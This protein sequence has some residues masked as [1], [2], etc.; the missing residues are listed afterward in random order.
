MK[1]NKRYKT[2]LTGVVSSL[3]VALASVNANAMLTEHD[4]ASE[5]PQKTY[6][7]II[8][9]R[10]QKV[11]KGSTRSAER[12]ANLLSQD[13]G[14]TLKYVRRTASNSHVMQLDRL[15]S[16]A[17]ANDIAEQIAM[18]PD[19]LYAEPD[20]IRQQAAIP[21][22]PLY[23]QQWNYSGF[24][25][26]GGINLPDAWDISTGKDVVVAVIDTGYRPHEDLQDKVL[27]GY[28]FI[29]DSFMA[30]D[31]N[32]RDNDAKDPGDWLEPGECGDGVPFFGQNSSWHGTHVAGTIAA[33][34]D[35][36]IGV[37][38][39]AWDA[40]ILPLR[41]LGKCG[42]FDSDIADA[43]LWA[44]G[45][46]VAGVPDNP[47][48]AKVLNL[49]LGGLE[50]DGKGCPQTFRDAIRA[51]RKAGATV[52]VAAGNESMDAKAYVP[53]NCPG[54]ITV[55]ATDFWGA[56]AIFSNFGS[57]VDVSAPGA[58]FL[59][60]GGILSTVNTGL[61]RPEDDGYGD[62]I[63]TSMSTPHVSGVAALMYA[64]EPDLKPSRVEEIIKKTAQPF[65]IPCTLCGTGIIDATAALND[66][67]SDGSK[68]SAT[69]SFKNFSR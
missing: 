43:M 60:F 21:N 66:L 29:S 62:K 54:V 48:P 38:G 11:N 12:N 41:V 5:M 45:V 37:T 69:Q 1:T 33:S 3:L 20:G 9:Y 50:E 55:G 24:R 46:P 32:E 19:V 26:S 51:V 4:Q 65:N 56:S 44:A 10:N 15:V 57:N 47:N 22:D 49:S 17:E 6:R 28:D 18:H 63:G 16:M 7:L 52:V 59:F 39:V 67:D 61:T 31:G 25:L 58:E 8:K 64:M 23:S 34:S 13:S 68:P 40:K 14:T 53:A 27:P 35:N 42:G 36:G 30:N 2:I